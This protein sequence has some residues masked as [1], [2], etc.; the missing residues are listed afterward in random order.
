[1]SEVTLALLGLHRAL[2]VEVDQPA[3]P[4]AVT[5][6]QHFP[7]DFRQRA[8]ARAQR[9]AQRVA[10]ERAEA[11][12]LHARP[13]AGEQPHALVVHHDQRA[14]ALHHRALVREVE[15]H[16]R[17]LF[18]VDVEPDVELGPIGERE[19]AD[20]LALGDLAVVEV[21]QLGPLVFGI[22]LAEAIAERVDALF[23]ARAFFVA[24]RTPESRVVAAGLQRLE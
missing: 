19:G 5:R 24:A 17:D 8:R 20:A 1:W 2:F 14:L 10:A 9:A 12:E 13:F 11:H 6:E 7:N 16:D 3:L 22:P 4:L 21:P 18:Q 23:G 15:R